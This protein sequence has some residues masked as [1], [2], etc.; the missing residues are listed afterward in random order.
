[1][2]ELIFFSIIVLIIIRLVGVVVSTD[3][4]YDTKSKTYIYFFIGW[5]LWAISLIFIILNESEHNSSIGI[6]LLFLNYILGPIAL[7]LILVGLTSYYL[8]IYHFK[9]FF[10]L[11]LSILI[12]IVLFII[13]G[14]NFVYYLSR[15]YTFSFYFIFLL[16]PIMKFRKFKKKVGK[17]IRWYYLSC[18]SILYY[19]PLSIFFSLGSDSYILYQTENINAIILSYVPIILTTLILIVFMIH[20][21]YNIS[22][23]QKKFLKDKYSH[24]LGNIFQGIMSGYNLNIIKEGS[25]EILSEVKEIMKKLIEEAKE[26]IEEIRN[27]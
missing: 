21:E 13:V 14:L 4:Y 5:G 1:L 16:L 27:L 17:S 8:K 3:F 10:F 6:I 18:F 26:I 2:N 15:I 7:I 25:E 22:S 19:I 20:L 24:N 23:D 12:S 9:I 11:I